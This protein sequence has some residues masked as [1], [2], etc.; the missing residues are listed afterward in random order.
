MKELIITAGGENIPPVLIEN[1]IKSALPC[2]AN[3]MALGDNRKYLACLI[4]LKED[5]P[6]SGNL[7]KAAI[8]FLASKGIAVKTLK[9]AQTHPGLRKVILDGLKVANDRAISR[10]QHVQDFCLLKE[11]F[12]VE[13]GT[14]TP[15]L[16]LKRKEVL[17]RYAA[18][19][20]SL[21]NQPKL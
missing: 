7:D 8:D 1:E 19:I 12:S 3:V 4:T 11:D 20:D 17:S 18:E 9:E 16:K 5:P 15:T 14:L 2:V 21:Y 10:A 13:N 6:M